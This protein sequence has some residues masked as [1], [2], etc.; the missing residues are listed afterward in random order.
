MQM[1]RALFLFAV[2]G[3]FGA[4][5]AGCRASAEVGKDHSSITM[6]R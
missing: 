2:L 5:M 1:K 3:L 4:A 6:P